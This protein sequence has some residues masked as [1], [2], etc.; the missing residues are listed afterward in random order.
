MKIRLFAGFP[1]SGLAEQGLAALRTPAAL[2]PEP[3]GRMALLA[4]GALQDLGLDRV[5]LQAEWGDRLSVQ[6]LAAACDCCVAGPVVAVTLGRLLR[7][8]PFERVLVL[9]DART[10]LEGL[11]RALSRH[12]SVIERRGLM[13]ETQRVLLHDPARAGHQA[14]LDLVAW[15]GDGMTF[16]GQ[17]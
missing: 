7:E 10:H 11:E 9:A 2:C 12:A 3:P 5:A 1:G 17:A 15:A 6:H 14:A 16:I 13:T 4:V 8:G